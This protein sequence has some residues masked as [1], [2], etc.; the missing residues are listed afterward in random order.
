M[1]LSFWRF[2]SGVAP[3]PNIFVLL[4]VQLWGPFKEFC[5]IT[6]FTRNVVSGHFSFCFIMM[7]LFSQLCFLLRKLGEVLIPFPAAFWPRKEGGSHPCKPQKEG[8]MFRFMWRCATKLNKHCS[9]PAERRRSGW[10]SP[11]SFTKV[12]FFSEMKPTFKTA[13]KKEEVKW[14]K[15]IWGLP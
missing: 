10:F 1:D 9:M 7:P 8:R 4:S 6:R 13:G 2:Y 11:A 15:S 5:L 14:N 12:A 3:L